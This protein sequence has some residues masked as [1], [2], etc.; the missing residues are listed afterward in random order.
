MAQLAD[1]FARGGYGRL[2]QERAAFLTLSGQGCECLLWPRTRAFQKESFTGELP[3][4]L[5]AIAHTHPNA[6]P[7]PSR[8]DHALANALGV[9]VIVVTNRSVIAAMPGS[10]RMEILVSGT[11]WSRTAKR[12]GWGCSEQGEGVRIAAR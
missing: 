1:L 2:P 3:K 8:G 9:P 7:T 4:D 12:A 5:V 6:T 10:P 11:L